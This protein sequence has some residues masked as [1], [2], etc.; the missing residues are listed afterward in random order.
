MT[1]R[2]ASS[3][4]PRIGL[5]LGSGG[6]RGWCHL[7]V[8]RGLE[9]LG[10]RPAAVAGCSMGAVVGAAC[11]GGRLDALEAWARALSM[12]GVL[13]YIDMRLSG[14]GIVEGAEIARLLHEIGL[15][16]RIEDLDMPFGTVATDLESGDEVWFT[17]GDL[18]TAVRGSLSIPGVFRPYPHG[19][20]WLLDGALC[21]PVPVT[22]ASRLAVDRVIAVDPNATGARP[23]WEATPPQPPAQTVLARVAQIELLPEMLRNWF[24]APADETGAQR[25]TPGYLEVVGTAIDIMQVKLLEQRLRAD[26]PDVFLEADLK[27]I[28]ILDL[29]RAAE[30]IDHGRAMVD[31]HAD[32]LRALIPRRAS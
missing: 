32:A 21:N 20:R 25:R 30:A 15:P 19:R 7:G 3:G 12:T 16:E 28:G 9:D 2:P 8:L 4:A 1:G 10:I 31:D 14:G 22:L 18:A 11:A 27:H 6:A 17:E 24:S 29:H 23:M 5:A 26:P 13:G